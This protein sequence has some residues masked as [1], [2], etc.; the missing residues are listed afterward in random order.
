[1]ITVDTVDSSKLQKS[2]SRS[3][4]TCVTNLFQLKKKKSLIKIVHNLDFLFP[5]KI[6]F[7]RLKLYKFNQQRHQT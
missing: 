2:Q 7:P 5:R 4:V 6:L 1:M 3:N